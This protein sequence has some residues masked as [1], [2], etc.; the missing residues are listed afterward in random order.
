MSMA[1]L[2]KLPARDVAEAALM[3]AADPVL[4]A[5]VAGRDRRL[6][7]VVRRCR[8]LP[9][10]E[11][12]QYVDEGGKLASVGSED[13]NAY[14]REAAA[15]NETQREGGGVP[16]PPGGEGRGSRGCGGRSDR[17]FE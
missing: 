15:E 3:V 7:Q 12:F 13:V 17:C 10:Q 1:V 9:G 11:L 6:A 8:E 16:F 2:E 5:Q 14:L 4:S